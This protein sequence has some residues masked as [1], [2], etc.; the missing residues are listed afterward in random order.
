MFAPTQVNIIGPKHESHEFKS[1]SVAEFSEIVVSLG[2]VVSAFQYKDKSLCAKSHELVGAFRREVFF[3]TS[4]HNS[5]LKALLDSPQ[6]PTSE[7]M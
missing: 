3:R 5:V 1:N 4:H 2:E 6:T 7:V